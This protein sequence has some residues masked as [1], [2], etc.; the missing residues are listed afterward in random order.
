MKIIK[1][2][3]IKGGT[4]LTVEVTH[5]EELIAIRPNTHYRLGG[6]MDDIVSSHTITE[7]VEVFWNQF[8]QKWSEA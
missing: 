6:Q 3:A 7:S 5:H 4:R 1:T 8:E 2:V